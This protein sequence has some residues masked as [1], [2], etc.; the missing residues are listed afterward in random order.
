MQETVHGII[1]RNIDF[2][3]NDKLVN[4]FT[5]EEGML[6]VTAFGARGSKNE[7]TAASQLFIY[8][9]YL[10]KERNRKLSIK[11]AVI[12]QTFSPIYHDYER[13]RIGCAMLTAINA[14]VHEGEK[15][16]RCYRLLYYCL[17]F[18]AYSEADGNDLLIAFLLKLL[19]F[20]GFAPSITHCSNCGEDL[21]QKTRI[22]FSNSS[23]GAV[24]SSCRNAYDTKTVDALTL[25][26]MR[27]ILRLEIKDLVKVAIPEKAKKQVRSTV[28]SY[29][30]SY[31]ET[32]IYR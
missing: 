29:A 32:Q 10:L 5:E 17:S 7:M 30:E 14:A 18:L 15:N 3:E 23:G 11:S 28:M 9:E 16:D 20:T 21:R 4:I 13:F 19:Q 31:L 8:G 12:D 27:R 25:E 2:H 26:I 1:T 24:C 22:Q 6:F